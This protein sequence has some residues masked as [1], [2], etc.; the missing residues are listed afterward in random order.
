MRPEDFRPDDLF[1]QIQGLVDTVQYEREARLRAEA[2]DKAKFDL[3]AMVSHELCTPM[4]AVISMSDLLLSSP[5]NPTQRRYTETLQQSARS[6]ATILNEMLDYSKLKAGSFEVENEPF[7]PHD[8]VQC[9]ASILQARASQKGLTAGFEICASCPRHVTGDAG[10]IRQ[11]LT[12]LIDNALKFTAS[13]GIRLKVGAAEIDGQLVLQFEVLDSG[14]GLT[15]EQQA[16]VFQP[17]VQAD[18]STDDRYGGTGLGLAITRRLVERM[19]GQIGCE[20]ALAQGSLFWFTV[21]I[22]LAPPVPVET[23]AEPEQMAL[24]G[25]VLV[26]EDNAVNRML[27]GAYLDEFGVTYDTVSSGA[28]A[29]ETLAERRYDLVIMDIMMP[30][31]DGTE[32]ARRIRAL[33]GQAA[34]VPIL[35]LTGNAMHGDRE[36]YLEAGMNA[37]LAKPIRGREL[38]RV[39]ES[40]LGVEERMAKAS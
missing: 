8:L 32:T 18:E 7:D 1:A 11:V 27:I 35:A 15:E 22:E 20:S 28:D 14:I 3:L 9:A 17:Y 38:Y 16:R 19:G 10:R 13:G 30:E 29:L 37:Y 34:Q 39:L 40:F 33:D 12:N 25:H 26:V 6:L 36:S 24:A 21:P 31:P 2:A 4:G 5:L 23:P